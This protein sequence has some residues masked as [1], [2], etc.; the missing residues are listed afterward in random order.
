M[1]TI[2]M[3]KGWVE[4]LVKKN[5]DLEEEVKN[6]KLR[7]ENS[8]PGQEV[9]QSR[10]E[11]LEQENTVLALQNS[12]LTTQLVYGTGGCDRPGQVNLPPRKR[13]RVRLV[14]YDSDGT[15]D[16]EIR[17]PVNHNGK[18][19]TTNPLQIAEILRHI[20]SYVKPENL[21]KCRQVCKFWNKATEKDFQDR[22]TFYI[23]KDDLFHLNSFMTQAA[24]SF[25]MFRKLK[26][27]LDCDSW[28]GNKKKVRELFITHG[29]TLRY[30][31]LLYSGTGCGEKHWNVDDFRDII[32]NSLDEIRRLDIILSC[33]FIREAQIFYPHHIKIYLES[34]TDLRLGTNC[35]EHSCNENINRNT[36]IFADLLRMAPNL[37]T[38]YWRSQ[39]YGTPNFVQ[40]I[41]Q[42]NPP[43]LENLFFYSELSVDLATSIANSQLKLKRLYLIDF[44]SFE[45]NLVTTPSGPSKNEITPRKHMYTNT[46]DASIVS[47]GGDIQIYLELAIALEMFQRDDVRSCTKLLQVVMT[48]LTTKLG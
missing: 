21:L 25:P 4:E 40:S 19:E 33:R 48:G 24:Q 42:V 31:N 1:A 15:S 28:R 36:Q 13:R 6:L 11:A 35:A 17:I 34:L 30:L 18:S 12:E 5:H 46:R 37:H 2:D 45:L 23:G 3:M 22:M 16:Q 9:L 29:E 14:Q 47:S 38:L 32:L 7:L 20:M 10:I 41:L 39:R 8:G 43:K 44:K 27:V 26:L